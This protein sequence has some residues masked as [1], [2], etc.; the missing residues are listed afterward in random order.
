[1]TRRTCA[2]VC[3]SHL[4]RDTCTLVCP[5]PPRKVLPVGRIVQLAPWPCVVFDGGVKEEDN[6][7]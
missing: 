4:H 7:E 5:E 3:P 6:A 2:T 1:M